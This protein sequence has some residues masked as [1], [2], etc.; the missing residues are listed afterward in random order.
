M[1][2]HDHAETAAH[3]HRP[4]QSRLAWLSL[5]LA[6]LLP[7][8]FAI[9]ALGTK[10]G[11]WS[12]RVGLGTM[13]REIGTWMMIIVS[14]LAIIAFLWAL[15]KKPRGRWIVPLIALA[16]PV[17]I[18]AML[19]SVSRTA[20]GNPIHDVATNPA[21]PP[22]FS[23]RI[24]QMRGPEANEVADYGVAQDELDGQTLARV[25]RQLYPEM[26]PLVTTVSPSEALPLVQAVMMEE[27]LDNVV[28]DPAAGRVEGTAETFWYGFK[29]DVVARVRAVQG[30]GSVID[31]RSVSRVGQ[32]DLGKNAER[33]RELKMAI[34][35]KL[36]Q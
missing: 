9:A 13:T 34:E 32:S 35:T 30:G 19:A 16:I 26:S 23:D 36:D 33:V 7:V 21:D 5:I 11:L 18:F 10:F 27:G 28:S 31:L 3:T 24:L 8:W 25:N 12:F 1:T 2:D 17:G 4:L 6:L 14:A 29:D 20:E 22:Q 15:I